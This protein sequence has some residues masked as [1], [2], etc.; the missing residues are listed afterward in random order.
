[1]TYVRLALY[2]LGAMAYADMA[3]QMLR[4]RHRAARLM[5]AFAVVW[6]FSCAFWFAVRLW[7]EWQGEW[8]PGY[9]VLSTV[10][11]GLIA[12]APLVFLLRFPNGAP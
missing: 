6:A 3:C 7:L 5:G 2:F 12:V 1:M 4:I 10:V 8:L 11:V 9:D